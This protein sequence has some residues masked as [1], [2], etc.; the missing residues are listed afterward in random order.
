MIGAEVSGAVEAGGYF[1]G[2]GDPTHPDG[3][4]FGPGTVGR[5][6]LIETAIAAAWLLVV[7]RIVD[8]S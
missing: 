4:V 7:W 5:W 2:R 6:M 8:G 1:G 3:D